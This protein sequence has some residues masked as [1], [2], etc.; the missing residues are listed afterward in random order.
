MGAA[1]GMVIYPTMLTFK[2]ALLQFVRH[3]LHGVI[4]ALPK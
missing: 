2:I 3:I 1:D 4:N